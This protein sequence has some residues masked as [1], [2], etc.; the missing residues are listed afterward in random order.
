M[1]CL[2]WLCSVLMIVPVPQ[3]EAC[4]TASDTAVTE[5]DR[6]AAD[7]RLLD[8][9]LGEAWAHHLAVDSS[10][11]GLPDE[12]QQTLA[13]EFLSEAMMVSERLDRTLQHMAA[14]GQHVTLDSARWKMRR[15]VACAAY[16]VLTDDLVALREA[17]TLLADVLANGGDATGRVRRLLILVHRSLGDHDQATRLLSAEQPIMDPVEQVAMQI[18][19][20]EPSHAHDWS[21]TVVRQLAQAEASWQ[22]QLLAE[23]GLAQAHTAAQ[24]SAIAQAWIDS[25]PRNGGGAAPVEQIIRATAARMPTQA[26]KISDTTSPYLVAGW[27]D[28]LVASDQ[29]GRGLSMADSAHM[30]ARRDRDQVVLLDARASARSAASDATGAVQDWLQASRL[31]GGQQS[32]AMLDAC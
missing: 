21:A 10:L 30:D 1:T 19:A 14:A 16:G 8:V 29:V 2:L 31:G 13:I 32:A 17:A 23:A 5:T 4:R 22:M 24:A 6:V 9:L 28:A 18:L 26:W 27:I 7:L 25:W 11:L 15:G 3:L 20:W 12:R